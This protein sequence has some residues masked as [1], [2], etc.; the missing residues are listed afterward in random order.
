MQGA[1][2]EAASLQLQRKLT[3]VWTPTSPKP[4]ALQK[5]RI[6]PAS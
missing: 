1:L 3:M 2:T 6:N 5:S 4:T